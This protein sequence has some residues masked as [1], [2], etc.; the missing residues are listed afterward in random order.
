MK[1]L[2][3][4]IVFAVALI[5]FPSAWAGD[6]VFQALERAPESEGEEFFAV[7]DGEAVISGEVIKL[8]V[9]KPEHLTASYKND[10]EEKVLPKYT[11]RIYTRYGF[12]LG[13]KK[14]GASLFGG[15]TTLEPGDVGGEKINLELI[16]LVAIFQHTRLELPDD[17]L[18]AAWVSFSDSNTLM[19][20]QE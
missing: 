15:S 16:D 13:S 4:A 10:G 9:V 17:F 14:V 8:V 1:H 11:V 2:R 20:T 18:K 19:G 7:K 5:T 6:S 3:I 12:L